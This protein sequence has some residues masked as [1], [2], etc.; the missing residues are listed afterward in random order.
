M[1]SYTH[2][3][4][5]IS[6]IYISVYTITC[7]TLCVCKMG[8]ANFIGYFIVTS[9]T[10]I[11]IYTFPVCQLADIITKVLPIKIPS[12]APGLGY[13]MLNGY[14]WMLFIGIE[15]EQIMVIIIE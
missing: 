7:D 8:Y 2:I 6:Y 5:Y 13:C 12:A 10:Y 15:M 11:Y 14:E 4:I 3:Y 1:K 9:C